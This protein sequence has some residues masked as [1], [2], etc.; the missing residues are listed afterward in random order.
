MP[1]FS[2]SGSSLPVSYFAIVLSGIPVSSATSLWV[3]PVSCLAFFILDGKTSLYMLIS[4]FASILA[5]LLNILLQFWHYCRFKNS[6]IY[7]II[8]ADREGSVINDSGD[9]V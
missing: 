5:Y 6:I 2:R 9:L 4:P 7:A 8:E 1:N 3:S